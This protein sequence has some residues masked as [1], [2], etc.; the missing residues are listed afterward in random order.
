MRDIMNKV[1]APCLLLLV[2]GQRRAGVNLVVQPPSECRMGGEQQ[3]ERL[4]VVRGLLSHVKGGP[5]DTVATPVLIHALRT[6]TSIYLHCSVLL[7]PNATSFT[8]QWKEASC[9]LAWTST[10]IPLMIRRDEYSTGSDSDYSK[11]ATM[12]VAMS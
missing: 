7:L 11:Y 1:W 9:T 2:V 10:T 12:A 8:M 4:P 5:C 3:I 6:P